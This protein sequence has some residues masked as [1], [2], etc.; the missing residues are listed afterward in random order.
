[1]FEDFSAADTPS[2]EAC[3][4]GVEQADAYILIL[5]PRYG[6]PLPETGQSPTHEEWEA[7]KRRGIPRLV[8]R[9][10]NVTFEDRQQGFYR[11]IAQYSTGVFHDDFNNATDLQVKIARRL[12]ELE[13]A[14]GPLRYE[15]LTHP[16]DA[17]ITWK[18]EF[19]ERGHNTNNGS[20]AMLELHVRDPN[21]KPTERALRLLGESLPGRVRKIGV[22]PESSALTTERHN[23]AYIALLPQQRRDGLNTP[24]RGRVQGIRLGADGQVSAWASMATNGIGSLFDTEMLP[25]EIA[26]ILIAI[27]SLEIITAGPV[28]IGVGIEPITMLTIGRFGQNLGS[29]TLPFTS[30]NDGVRVEP[31]EAVSI[32]A[33]STGAKEVGRNLT[34]ALSDRLSF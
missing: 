23:G 12:R 16:S 34:A 4:S 27:G 18:S 26:E 22:L 21:F 9:K 20:V 19:F 33:L 11:E 2:R 5:G 13:S 17:S 6:D 29:A 24:Q 31:D 15:R 1:M 30:R 28:I 3:L 14:P 10:L 32:A 7:A 8:Y 25:G